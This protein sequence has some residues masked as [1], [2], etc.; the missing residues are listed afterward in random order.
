MMVTV[1]RT[2]MITMMKIMMMEMG[3]MMVAVT[4]MKIMMITLTKTSNRTTTMIVKRIMREVIIQSKMKAVSY[5]HLTLPTR[6][7][8]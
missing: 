2:K 6:L 8:V 1:T 4:M 3:K 5:T 7:S